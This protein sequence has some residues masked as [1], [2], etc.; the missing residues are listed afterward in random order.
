MAL[1][2]RK[3]HLITSF[4]FILLG[5]LGWSPVALSQDELVNQPDIILNADTLEQPVEIAPQA[6]EFQSARLDEYVETD[7]NAY[8]FSSKTVGRGVKVFE[9]AYS[10]VKIGKQRSKQSAPESLFRLG[11][12]DRVEARLGYNFETGR[13]SDTSEGDII[14]N[15]GI[16]AQQQFFY[17]FK[18]QTTFRDENRRLIPESVFLIHGNTPVGSIEGQSQIRLGQSWSWELSN[19]WTLEQAVQFG[20]DREEDDFYTLWAPSTVLRIPLDTEKRWFTQIEYFGVMSH[21]R[22]VEFSKQFID[23]GLHYLITPHLEIGGYV[24]MGINKQSRGALVNFGIGYR[25]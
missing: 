9:S 17:G 23:T 3:K 10:Y 2:S 8:T 22:S 11:L 13:P 7:R 5:L 16:N 12:T 21:N 15:F 14:T 4:G 1:I 18:F 20:T 24:A 6:R 25:F 19:G